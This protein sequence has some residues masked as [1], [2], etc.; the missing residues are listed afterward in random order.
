MLWATGGTALHCAH[1]GE[2]QHALQQQWSDEPVAV[3][4]AVC[5]MHYLLT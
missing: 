4:E 1:A 2:A 3:V 5:S